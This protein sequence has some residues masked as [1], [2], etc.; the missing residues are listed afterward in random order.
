MGNLLEQVKADVEAFLN[1]EQFFCNECHLQMELAAYL[2]QSKNNYCNVHLEYFVPGTEVQKQINES[3]ALSKATNKPQ[4]LYIDIVVEKKGEFLPIELK[5]KTAPLKKDIDRFGKVLK[6][7]DVLK[8]HGARDLGAYDFWRDVSR[9]ECLMKRFANVKNGIALFLTNDQG[10]WTLPKDGT[11][12][13]YA[14][15]SIKEKKG[16]HCKEKHWQGNTAM[17]A[18]RPSFNLD[19]E[20]ELEWLPQK[21][22]GYKWSNKDFRYCLLK[23]E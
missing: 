5:Y 15:F 23:I 18:A 17:S 11:N 13:N 2:R 12:P 9:I 4:N 19:R 8:N 14:N 1:Q 21:E 3:L 10:Y 16:K 20:Y 22:K 6:G 7:V